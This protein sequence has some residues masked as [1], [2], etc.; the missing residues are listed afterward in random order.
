MRIATW[1]VNGIRARLPR[2]LEWLSETKPDVVLLQELKAEDTKFP[3]IEL[4]AAGYHAVLV[5]QASYNGVAI[6]ARGAR[7]ELVTDTLEGADREMGARFIRARVFGVDFASVY[8]PNGKTVEHDDYERKL[9]W[10]GALVEAC[11]APAR[12]DAPFVLGG[13]FN[14]CATDKDSHAPER[15]RD[16]IFHTARERARYRELSELGLTDLFRKVEPEAPG[17]SWWD[18]RG[19]S[20]HKNE[21]LRIDLLFGNR[22]ATERLE[23]VV[24]EREYRKKGKDGAA[25]SDHTPVTCTLRD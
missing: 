24:V 10:L 12:S 3:H 9:A 6:L 8:V 25:A 5:G 20:F 11:R 22:A 18:Y 1:N 16:T 2:V 4:T 15:L 19:G 21:G 7:P 13:D 14:L 23:A 17:F